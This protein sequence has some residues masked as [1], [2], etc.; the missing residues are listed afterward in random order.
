M[1]VF[2]RHLSVYVSMSR[3]VYIEKRCVPTGLFIYN[4]VCVV[5]RASTRACLMQCAA[6]GIRDSYSEAQ[7]KRAEELISL[8][9][10]ATGLGVFQ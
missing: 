9:G 10:R 7:D 5:R 2:A 1:N 3:H 6:S 8:S 4:C